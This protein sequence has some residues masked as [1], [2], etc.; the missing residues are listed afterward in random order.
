[1]DTQ[2]PL[3][4]AETPPAFHRSL[5]GFGVIILTL[6]VL[7]PAVSVF[8]GGAAILQQ[9]GTGAVIAFL[10]GAAV[11][12]CQTAMIA[13][14]G[15][16]YPSAGYD[17]AAI[18]HAVGDWAGAT[19]YVASL[20]AF[21]LFLNLAASG[22]ATY[23]RPLGL[24]LDPGITTLLVIALVTGLAMLNI[25]ANEYLTGLFLLVEAAALLLV[26]GIGAWFAKPGAL[27]LVTQPRHLDHGVWVVAGIGVIGI[28]INNAAWAL[29][30]ASQA[31]M[32]SEDM[33]HPRTIGRIMMIALAITVALEIAPIIGTIIGARDLTAVMASEAPFE[34]FIAQ[35]LPH[36]AVQIF[37]LA[38]AL[39]VFNAC[40]AGF[41]GV[42]LTVFSMGR[43]RL[44]AEPINR[45]L[46]RMS[47]RTDAPWVAILV[48][49]IATAG[50]TYVP[51]V[52]KVLILSGG[53][54]VI[55]IFYIW[56]VLR[57]RRTGRTGAGALYRSPLFPLIPLLGVLIVLGEV[58]VLWLDADLGRP[59]LFICLGVYGLA[60]L[61]YRLVLR[62]RPGGWRLT[63]P[64]DIDAVTAPAR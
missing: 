63:G 35:H 28:A 22:V 29:A 20:V 15:A 26:A 55:S 8:V 49:A 37:S 12:Y 17:Y 25:K 16:A 45:A 6:S 46:T 36:G 42:G 2:S 40:L 59:S 13:E 41:V 19:T 9:A 60:F 11:C 7:S 56:G 32:F 38:I 58:T 5:S 34:A 53:I 30:G 43:T 61:Y 54:S 27:A 51:L 33:K 23:L 14:L 48:L 4:M 62:R 50:V 1:M 64:A 24:P 57:G 31:L 21:P 44:F 3:L 39:A 10:V 52:T 47:R 18:G